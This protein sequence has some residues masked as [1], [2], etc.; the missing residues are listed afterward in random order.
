MNVEMS[1]RQLL[2]KEEPLLSATLDVVGGI[3]LFV[4][5]NNNW[6]QERKDIVS[7][8]IRTELAKIGN[9]ELLFDLLCSFE[10]R[11]RNNMLT[12]LLSLES[13][14]N[15]TVNNNSNYNNYNKVFPNKP[16]EIVQNVKRF[17]FL[18]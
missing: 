2:V 6:D 10:S 13:G 3:S 4:D 5:M 7:N 15:K 18:N 16:A 11:K 9:K 12:T 17:F 14:N 8:L 1:L